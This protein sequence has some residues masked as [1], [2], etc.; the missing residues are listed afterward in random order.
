MALEY[1]VDHALKS[2]AQIISEQ[3]IRKLSVLYRV[4]E[5]VFSIAILALTLPLLIVAVLA[6]VIESPGNPFFRQIRLGKGGREFEMIKLRTMIPDAELHCGPKLAERNDPR[7]TLVG[8]ILRRTRIDELPQFVNVIKGEMAI[9][10]PRP[11]RPELYD[12][13]RCEVPAYR[14]RLAVRPGITGLAQTR[15]DYH[16]DFRHKLRYDLLYISNKS[17][18]LDLKIMAATLL[19]VLSRKGSA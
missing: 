18:L 10:G 4:F 15:G 12:Q 5:V 13:I 6:I 14:L 1:H 19:V 9:V 3:S 8:Y 11:E 7:I 2:A 16:L 17:L